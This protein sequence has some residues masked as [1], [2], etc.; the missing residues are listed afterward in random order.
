MGKTSLFVWLCLWRGWKGHGK[1]TAVLIIQRRVSPTIERGG[2]P[3]SFTGLSR[4]RL[5][6]PP[7]PYMGSHHRRCCGERPSIPP[8]LPGSEAADEP[9]CGNPALFIYFESPFSL[10]MLKGD[11]KMRG[12][13]GG[14]GLVLDRKSLSQFGFDGP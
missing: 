12:L 4:A 1:N 14:H 2:R 7:P 11:L 9:G 8:F 6:P 3:R 13:L 5:P 10:A